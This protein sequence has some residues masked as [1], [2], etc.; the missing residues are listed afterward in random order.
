M[1][2]LV[3][4][5]EDFLT[6]VSVV[7]WEILPVSHTKFAQFVQNQNIVKTRMVFPTK[8]RNAEKLSRFFNDHLSGYWM[9]WLFMQGI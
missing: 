5:R 4:K 9:Y 6:A 2:I 3:E 8:Y 1:E 7:F